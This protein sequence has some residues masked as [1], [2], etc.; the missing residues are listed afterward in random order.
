MDI[1]VGGVAPSRLMRWGDSSDSQQKRKF[2]GKQVHGMRQTREGT[3]QLKY[4][5]GK[6]RHGADRLAGHRRGTPQRFGKDSLG[7]GYSRTVQIIFNGYNASTSDISVGGWLEWYGTA[8]QVRLVV[9]CMVGYEALQ[10]VAWS[11]SHSSMLR[12]PSVGSVTP[13]GVTGNR[14]WMQGNLLDSMEFDYN[15]DS[16]KEG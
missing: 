15:D 1:V 9:I 8:S 10:G 12:N 4:P 13:Q 7:G 2:N 14:M 16:V 6:R 3:G 5:K 11:T